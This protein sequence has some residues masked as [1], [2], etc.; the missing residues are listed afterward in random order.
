LYVFHIGLPKTGTSTIQA[1]MAAN[2]RVLEA[3]GILYPVLG[4]GNP[5]PHHDLRNALRDAAGIA[6]PI[7]DEFRA[8]RD[9]AREGTVLVSSEGFSGGHTVPQLARE[10]IGGDEARVIVYVRDLLSWTVSSYCQL[11]KQGHPLAS[12]DEYLAASNL[13]RLRHGAR[14]LRWAEAFGAENVRIR[15]LN[16]GCLVNG[17]LIDDFLSALGTTRD[18]LM[19]PP[20]VNETPDWRVVELLREKHARSFAETGTT[21]QRD[22]TTLTQRHISEAA[23]GAAKRL[24]WKERAEYLTREQRRRLAA[25]YRADRE[26][27]LAAVPDARISDI[28]PDLERER[29]FLPSP[30]AVPEADRQ[31]FEEV[32]QE[33]LARRKA[34]AAKEEAGTGAA[35]GRAAV[36][37]AN[38]R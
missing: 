21:W 6:S 22:A 11:A 25:R 32:F 18:G 14:I 28:A 27:L 37:P 30:E 33:I 17:D 35:G 29:P 13:N 5:R 16:R 1:L 7:W 38:R 3:R 2:A 12:F 31:A 10:G 36:S 4:G 19:I 20:N 8:L 9:R 15:S 23:I 34:E 24:G 26:R